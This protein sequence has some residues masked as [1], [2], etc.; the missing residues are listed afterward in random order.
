MVYQIIYCI[1]AL[2]WFRIPSRQ[3]PAGYVNIPINQLQ[4]T[5]G[6]AALPTAPNRRETPPPDYD[7]VAESDAELDCQIRLLNSNKE[8]QE[9]GSKYR[10]FE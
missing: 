7:M 10:R 2:I 4:A 6:T 9:K 3:L 8:D 1:N 5:K